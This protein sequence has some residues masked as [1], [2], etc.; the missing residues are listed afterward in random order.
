MPR[1][2]RLWQSHGL[3]PLRS[4]LGG[5]VGIATAALIGAVIAG[6]GGGPFLLASLGASAVL[7]FAVPASPLAQPRAIIG[8]NVVSALAGVVVARL[9]MMGTGPDDLSHLA[10]PLAL[11]LATAIVAMHFT[12]CLHPPGGAVALMPILGGPAISA[13]GYGFVL[14][15]VAVNSLAL[16]A[17]AWAFN[18]LA[19]SRYP[20]RPPT[21]PAPAAPVYTRA[22]LDAVLDGMED[23]PDIA[24]DEL[25]AIFRA[26]IARHAGQSPTPASPGKL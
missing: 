22:D 24:A 13:M 4:S 14:F 17:A 11:A 21:M 3:H 23:L 2:L 9:A 26:V 6:H 25:D 19:G 1:Y 5:A 15:P 8:G 18:N 12:R 10:I 20:H 7:A 16:V